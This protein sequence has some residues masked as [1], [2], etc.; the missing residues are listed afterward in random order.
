[1]ESRNWKVPFC[2]IW[3]G[4]ALSLVGS[5]LVQFAPI[6]WL[7]ETTGSA[8]VLATATLAPFLPPAQLG[9]MVGALVDR[10]RRRWIMGVSRIPTQGRLQLHRMR[11]KP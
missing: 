2:T 10:W 9:P 11:R 8:A 6:W 7:T 4:Q 5:A 1:M 3:T